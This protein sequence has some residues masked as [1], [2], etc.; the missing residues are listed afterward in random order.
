MGSSTMLMGDIINSSKYSPEELADAMHE[1]GRVV[2]DKFASLMIG[3]VIPKVGDEYQCLCPD[4]QSAISLI[5]AIE[6]YF[7][8]SKLP[9]R[10]RFALA[11]GDFEGEK[12]SSEWR[13]SE[14]LYGAHEALNNKEI[15]RK[16]V[17][18]TYTDIEEKEGI[19][20]LFE[21]VDEIWSSWNPKDYEL[22]YY[23]IREDDLGDVAQR[24]DKTKQ[25]IK[26]RYNTL[27]I[28]GY[29]RLKKVIIA[30][31]KREGN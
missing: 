30:L 24:F 29:K 23:M 9:L 15:E 16:K 28:E 13:Y 6:E 2:S 19:E 10:S 8:M 17:L 27:Q 4:A 31:S 7:L 20:L 18:L 12:D 26:K 14:K 1:F 25:Q 11:E 21:V 22:I 3:G 5:F